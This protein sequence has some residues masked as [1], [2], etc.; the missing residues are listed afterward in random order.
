MLRGGAIFVLAYGLIALPLDLYAL[1]HWEIV[2][3]RSMRVAI[4]NPANNHGDLLGTLLQQS[5][6]VARMFLI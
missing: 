2:N 1:G 4:L 3:G 6:L 5:V